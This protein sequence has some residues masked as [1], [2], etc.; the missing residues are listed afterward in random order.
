MQNAKHVNVQYISQP[1]YPRG[2]LEIIFRSWGTLCENQFLGGQWEK[3]SLG[4]QLV[5]RMPPPF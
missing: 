3:Y 4:W 2:N 5:E 1:F